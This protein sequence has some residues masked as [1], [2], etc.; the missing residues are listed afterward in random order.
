VFEKALEVGLSLLTELKKACAQK[1]ML[2]MAVQTPEMI[3]VILQNVPA[4]IAA[5][6]LVNKAKAAGIPVPMGSEDVLAGVIEEMKKD[7]I[8]IPQLR[9][10]LE[11]KNV[12]AVLVATI[13]SACPP[14]KKQV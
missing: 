8:F 7:V 1:E 9:R 10:A 3:N 4:Q 2:K 14:P 6:E 11:D 12:Q 5:R 13:D